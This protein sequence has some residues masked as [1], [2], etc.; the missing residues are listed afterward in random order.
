MPTIDEDFNRLNAS[1]FELMDEV[2]RLREERNTL[3]LESASDQA[4]LERLREELAARPKVYFPVE[5]NA[6]LFAEL[7]RLREALS[8]ITKIS[9]S[10]AGAKDARLVARHVMG[11]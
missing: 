9:L 1:R 11:L 7:E 2:S 6:D 10:V 8:T 5:E 3:L 4:E